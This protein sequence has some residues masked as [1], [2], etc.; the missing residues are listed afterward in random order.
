MTLRWP[1]HHQ[2]ATHAA[3]CQ[4]GLLDVLAV[5][6][7][8]DMPQWPANRTDQ[9]RLLQLASEHGVDVLVATRE[10]ALSSC[11]ADLGGRLALIA[12]DA[13]VIEAVRERELRL[14]LETLH[15]QGVQALLAKGTA[16]A[17]TVYQSPEHRPRVD[18]DVLVAQT[19]V[20]VAIRALEAH[21]YTRTPQNVGQLVSH[22]I[23]LARLDAHGVWHAIDLHWKVVNPH[24]FANLVTVEELMAGSVALPALGPRART[25]SA[26]HALVIATVHLAAHHTHQLRLIWLY[27]LHLLCGRLTFPEFAAVV[28]LARSRG[29]ATVC[30]TG[31]HAA[32]RWFDTR[33]PDEILAALDAVDAATEEPARYLAGSAGKLATLKSDLRVLPSW[34]A[35]ARL[36]YEHAFPPA[37]F[38]LR[39]Y[40]RSRRTWLPALYVHRMITGGLRWL[41][42]A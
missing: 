36:L 34:R 25:L 10:A 21:G 11:P 7:R 16:L 23:A 1:D 12:R 9:D 42:Q 27:D 4:A 18:T 31:L 28:E 20:E 29:L 13:A 14:V 35:R 41:R 30:A 2:P 6:V 22:Q 15:H 24:V 32:R 3:G 5:V 8:G 26:A 38:M 40:H 33:V 39:S 17:Y 19:H 37:D